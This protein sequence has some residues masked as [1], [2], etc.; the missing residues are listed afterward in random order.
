MKDIQPF[1]LIA[2]KSQKFPRFKPRRFPK[3][4]RK[5]IAVAGWAF[6]KGYQIDP[7]PLARGGSVATGQPA[8][9]IFLSPR[10]K[11][12]APCRRSTRRR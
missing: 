11:P 5:A 3:P 6:I 12:C 4:R 8:K 9:I 2:E 7:Y 10:S 1:A